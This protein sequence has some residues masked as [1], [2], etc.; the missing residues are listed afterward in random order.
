MLT[1]SN[2]TPA[3]ADDVDVSQTLISL[4]L[5]YLVA[6]RSALVSADALDRPGMQIGVTKGSTSERTLPARF[7]HARI[8][9][10]ENARTAIAMLESGALDVYATN[11]PTLYEMSDAM[12]GGRILPGN[13]GL[14]H[15]AIAIPKG[16]PQALVALRQFVSDVQSSG[17]LE[18]LKQRAGL[19]GAVTAGPLRPASPC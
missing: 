15:I 18:Q 5:G 12:A 17:L 10:A 2:A 3:R 13:W 11:K 7:T 16:R 4:E 6:A 19:R 14:E 9:P 8:V 1:L